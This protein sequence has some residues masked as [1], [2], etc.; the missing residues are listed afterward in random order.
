MTQSQ[1]LNRVE[2]EYSIKSLVKQKGLQD[3]SFLLMLLRPVTRV[4][5]SHS[6]RPLTASVKPT[7][8]KSAIWGYKL[9]LRKL[10]LSRAMHIT[11]IPMCESRGSPVI[12]V[13][14]AHPRCFAGT[15]S[16]NNYA[17]LVKDEKTNDA[18]IVDPANPPE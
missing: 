11:S 18:V 5:S 15:G 1:F 7:S 10:S 3:S 17:Y 12:V 9:I 13:A 16:S 8:P 2:D 6:L 14:H 4:I